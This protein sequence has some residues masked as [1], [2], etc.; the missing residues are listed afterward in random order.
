MTPNDTRTKKST[1]SEIK[2]LVSLVHVGGA[3]VPVG[4]VPS[5]PVRGRARDQVEALAGPAR[6]V[7]GRHQA[8]ERFG[9]R[10]E[11][12]EPPGKGGLFQKM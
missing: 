6:H 5:V 8:G 9:E 3:Q 11:R 10:A 1:V 7:V 4:G 2:G 12:V